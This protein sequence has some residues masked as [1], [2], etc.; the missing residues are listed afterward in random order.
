MLT[1]VCQDLRCRHD[2][3]TGEPTKAHLTAE[4]LAR[5]R[6]RCGEHYCGHSLAAGSCAKT[7]HV[8]KSQ[9][10]PEQRKINRDLNEQMEKSLA[11]RMSSVTGTAGRAASG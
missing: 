8:I 1:S 7:I 6:A 11:F 2:I 3:H 9:E 4:D 5:A 10:V